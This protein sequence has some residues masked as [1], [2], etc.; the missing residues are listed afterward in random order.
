MADQS[1]A[2]PALRWRRQHA[3]DG[4][5]GAV[6]GERAR[7]QQAAS[8]RID[9]ALAAANRAAV[10]SVSVPA[11]DAPSAGL[12]VNAEADASHELA[13]VPN[14]DAQVSARP[15]QSV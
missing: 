9:A 12:P 7:L 15:E 4:G 13:P 11:L 3:D 2:A 5:Y 1:S 8:G 14:S 10:V 6:L